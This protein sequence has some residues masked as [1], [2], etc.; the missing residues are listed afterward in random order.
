MSLPFRQLQNV[1]IGSVTQNSGRYEFEDIP[2]TG[3]QSSGV[4]LTGSV[5]QNLQHT[6][7][8]CVFNT[9]ISSITYNYQVTAPAG[10]FFNAFEDTLGLELA[11][12]MRFGPSYGT[13]FVDI[14][15]TNI[16]SKIIPKID[17]SISQVQCLDDSNGLHLPNGATNVLPVTFTPAASNSYSLAATEAFKAPTTDQP[18]YVRTPAT[19]TAAAA[20][21]NV[22][23]V[24]PLGLLTGTLF[25]TKHDQYFGTSMI[26]SMNTAPVS[27]FGFTTTSLST[28]S[29]ALAGAAPFT[30]TV[31]LSNIYLNLA[32][33]K[34]PKIIDHFKSLAHSGKLRYELPYTTMMSTTVSAGQG[35]ANVNITSANGRKMKRIVNVA[36][37][38]AAPATGVGVYD[39]SNFSGSKITSFSSQLSGMPLQ[40]KSN[41]NCVM[42][43][44][45]VGSATY[46]NVLDERIVDSL[47]DHVSRTRLHI[48][49]TG[50]TAILGVTDLIF[51]GLLI[52]IRLM[53]DSL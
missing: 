26:L 28:G 12:S 16:Y 2:L 42:A 41:N 20:V 35:S 33:Q 49:T 29:A 9:D 53:K 27:N 39:I 6:I 51:L 46:S 10:T 4:T 14:T 34:D 19:G 52:Q 40:R 17:A 1:E 18:Q 30:G 31:T 22:S 43:S 45:G 32:V 15:N 13:N 50:S 36:Q 23:R 7:P 24:I 5:S 25:S 37:L 21:Y 38:A 47:K 44:G 11:S 3:L 48:N 8:D